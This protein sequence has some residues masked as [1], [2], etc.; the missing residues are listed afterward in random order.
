MKYERQTQAALDRFDQSLAK[1]RD[2]IK[3][4]EQENALYF[5]EEGE[6]KDRFE[7]LQSIIKLSYVNPLG[8]SGIP[9][10]GNI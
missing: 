4:G 1:L 10:T 8:A 5:M 2:L 7:A 9:N 6:L 3:R